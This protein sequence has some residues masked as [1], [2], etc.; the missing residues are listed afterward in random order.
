MHTIRPRRRAQPAQVIPA[1]RDLHAAVHLLAEV[2][3]HLGQARAAPNA[4]RR[5]DAMRM[6][7]IY[8]TEVEKRLAVL[9]V[10][11][12]RRRAAELRRE[13]DRLQLEATV[14]AVELSRRERGGEVVDL[15]A[16]RARRAERSGGR[17]RR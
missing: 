1:L 7:W 16:A 4:W 3:V 11:G 14:T 12:L 15:A 17:P 5:A 9:A 10:P 2:R 6:V 13:A 8:L